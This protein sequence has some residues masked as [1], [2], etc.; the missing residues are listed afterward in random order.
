MKQVVLQNGKEQKKF[1]KIR[2][3]GKSSL[4]FPKNKSW[5]KNPTLSSTLILGSLLFFLIYALPSQAQLAITSVW[6]Q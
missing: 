1:P 2:V 4:K 6:E 5:G 3:G